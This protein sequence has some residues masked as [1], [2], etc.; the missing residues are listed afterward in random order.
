MNF[1]LNILV[2]LILF[3]AINAN[4][5]KLEKNFNR[6][7]NL[8]L[9]EKNEEAEKYLTKALEIDNKYSNAYYNRGVARQ[10]MEKYEDAAKDFNWVISFSEIDSLNFRANRNNS[11]IY[12]NIFKKNKLALNYSNSALKFDSTS[13]GALHLHGLILHDLEYYE[14]AIM[15]FNKSLKVNPN[16]PDPYYDRA[17]TKRKLERLEDALLDYNKVI[18]LDP[19][20]LKAYNN[21]GYVHTLLLNYSE[22]INDFNMALK[23]EPDAYGYNNRGFAKLKIGDL[24]GAKKDCEL[25][26]K[27]NPKNSWAYHYL[28]LVYFKMG[29]DIKGCE[30]LNKS[31]ELGKVEVKQEIEQKCKK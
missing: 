10:R 19:K 17:I 27:L 8:L 30:L 18:E 24:K 22:A 6:G 15:F 23:I 7:Y 16:N 28:G 14:N 4:S 12:R 9:E 26:M 1:K 3:T 5:Q 31:F 11:F 21:R 2:L 29:D 25:S 20:Y 13:A